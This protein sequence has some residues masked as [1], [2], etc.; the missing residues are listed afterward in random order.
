M[1]KSSHVNA[2]TW[3]AYVEHRGTRGDSRHDLEAFR[4][5]ITQWAEAA[6]ALENRYFCNGGRTRART[7]D[8]LI[9]S[10]LL[11]QLSYAPES[12]APAMPSQ[13]GVV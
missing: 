9:K 4:A 13:A 7:W 3:A 12:Y 5:A 10:Q 2:Q 11:Y 1:K 6:K 8:P